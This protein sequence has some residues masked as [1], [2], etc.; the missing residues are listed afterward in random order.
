MPGRQTGSKPWPDPIFQGF[1]ANPGSSARSMPTAICWCARPGGASSRR[2]RSFPRFEL[3]PG[4]MREPEHR[5]NERFLALV[6][7]PSARPRRGRR[8]RRDGRVPEGAL[9]AADEELI[10]GKSGAPVSPLVSLL[11]LTGVET[12]D[13]LN[14]ERAPSYWERSDR[15][16]LAL[17]LTAGRRGHFALAQVIETFLSHMLN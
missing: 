14:D 17:D 6:R 11:G 3:L 13:V 4:S 1:R 15:F 8:P 12:I 9:L 2:F 10:S 16:D 5:A 7:T